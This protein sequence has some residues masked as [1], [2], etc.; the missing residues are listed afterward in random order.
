MLRPASIGR[1]NSAGNV[2][3]ARRF[4][5]RSK[6]N[7]IPKNGTT[8][9][10]LGT[11]EAKLTTNMRQIKRCQALRYQ[12]FYEEMNA[13][14]NSKATAKKRDV[15]IFDRVCDHVMVL[16][17]EHKEKRV[18]R[19]RPKLVGTYRLLRQDVAEKYSGFYSS[20][21]FDFS[22]M[23][24]IHRDKKFLELGRS[25]VLSDYR[26]KHTI[27]LLWAAIW[28]YVLDHKMDVMIGCAS[29]P[30]TNPDEIADELSFLHHFVE[31]PEEWQ[32]KAL[33]DLY[34]DMNRKAKE[35]INP[36]RALVKLPPLIKGYL[37]VGAFVGNGAIVDKQFGTTDV[38]MILP[39]ANISERYIK[40]F[41]AD[42]ERHNAS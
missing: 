8:L 10:K 24:D 37:R 23:L 25:C 3:L 9:G 17:H 16:D 21:E 7:F 38:F 6:S 39:V 35:E 12:V 14:A 41:G 15:D 26:G 19:N 31:T 5:L 11:L 29:F 13:I 40:Y 22:E 30:T 34:V 27:E 2:R 33:P 42:A 36:K 1:R 4:A 18:G 28:R 20:D 32:A